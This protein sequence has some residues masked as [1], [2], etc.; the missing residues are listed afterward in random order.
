MLKVI[1]LNV[2]MAI[3][4][5]NAVE[6][7]LKVM[8]VKFNAREFIVITNAVEPLLRVMVVSFIV[9]C[10]V[11]TKIKPILLSCLKKDFLL[12]EPN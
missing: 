5:T 7:L 10:S 11:I 2:K 8:V 6:P 4:I 12:L 1:K 3:V 9:L